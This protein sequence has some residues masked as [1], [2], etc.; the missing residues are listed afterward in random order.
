MNCDVSPYI[1][2]PQKYKTKYILSLFV[3]KRY[4]LHTKLTTTVNPYK[5]ITLFICIFT[6]IPF[7]FQKHNSSL[8]RITV[9]NEL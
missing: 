4:L 8:S 9:T 5:V 2:K 6:F 7:K 3:Y 1:Q